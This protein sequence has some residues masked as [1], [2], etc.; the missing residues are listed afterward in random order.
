MRILKIKNLNKK[1]DEDVKERSEV[2]RS[3]FLSLL[4]ISSIISLCFLFLI[5]YVPYI[6]LRSISSFAPWI[7]GIFILFIAMFVLWASFELTL[8]ILFKK[9]FLFSSKL[10]GVTIKLF[11]PFVLFVGKLFGIPQSKIRASFIKA[12]NELVMSENR[13][14]LPQEVL[15]LLPHCLQNSKCKVR[16]TYELDNCKRCG[17]C[18]IAY[19]LKLK[20][21]FKVHAAIATGGTIARRIVVQKKPKFIIAVACERDLA[22]GIQDTYPIPVFG[23]LNQRP[24]GPCIDTQVS[25]EILEEA[26]KR[27]V[28]K[29]D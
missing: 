2:K 3:L 29:D 17:M 8:N 28:K 22:S 18:P 12:N 5:W 10:R 19:I 16:I 15:I 20:E 6:G 14:F 26:L 1:I 4:V 27:F 21:K 24:Y 23:I 13:K 11:F 7:W 25:V 9:G